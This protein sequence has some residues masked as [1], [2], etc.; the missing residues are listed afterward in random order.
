MIRHPLSHRAQL[1]ILRALA[2]A[3]AAGL[4][5]LALWG[6][7][8]GADEAPLPYRAPTPGMAMVCWGELPHAV[9]SSP[10]PERVQVQ[11]YGLML[12][13]DPDAEWMGDNHTLPARLIFSSDPDWRFW[14]CGVIPERSPECMPWKPE[15][16]AR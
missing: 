8:A 6:G 14:T 5:G 10:L 3:V 4:I 9:C 1:R 2:A 15:D 11:V 13:H 16:S 12:I 7:G